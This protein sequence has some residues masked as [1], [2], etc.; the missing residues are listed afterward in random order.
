MLFL[1]RSRQPSTSGHP[2]PSC[3]PRRC[4]DRRSSGPG[5]RSGCRCA[6]RCRSRRV[7][8]SPWTHDGTRGPGQARL[9]GDRHEGVERKKGEEKP[10]TLAPTSFYG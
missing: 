2:W 7:A 6:G 1:L 9:Q 8:G 10:G 3:R 4:A 5:I